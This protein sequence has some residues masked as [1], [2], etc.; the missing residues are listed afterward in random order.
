MEVLSELYKIKNSD[1]KEICIKHNLKRTGNKKELINRISTTIHKSLIYEQIKVIN[2]KYLSITINNYIKKDFNMFNNNILIEFCNSN[3]IYC[4]NKKKNVLIK[5]ITLYFK[6]KYDN[7]ISFIQQYYRY[8]IHK[9]INKLKGPALYNRDLCNNKSDFFNLCDIKTIPNKYFFSFR[10]KDNFIYGFEIN[11]IYKMIEF[12]KI[13][14]YNR[15]QL[16]EETLNNIIYI[17][18]L[19]NISNSNLVNINYSRKTI[20]QSVTDI[21]QTIDNLGNYTNVSWFLDL[22]IYKLKN[23]YKELEDIWNYR[24]SLTIEQKKE[25]IHPTGILF[26]IPLSI[27]YNIHN[28][29]KLQIICIDIMNKLITSGINDD[30]KKQGCYYILMALTLVSHDAAISLPWLTNSVIH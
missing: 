10:D 23:F 13:N 28:K 26:R 27:I 20:E 11:S 3:N 14:P 4:I 16:S 2:N 30:C 8:Y 5:N 18:K 1:L 22:N 19:I 7:K 25:I 6:D 12:E 29:T 24:L 17:Y 21:F 15:N 9:K